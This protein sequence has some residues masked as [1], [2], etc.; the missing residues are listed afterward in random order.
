[1]PYL[2]E[3][4]NKKDNRGTIGMRGTHGNYLMLGI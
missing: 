3:I 1:M 4:T 2:S